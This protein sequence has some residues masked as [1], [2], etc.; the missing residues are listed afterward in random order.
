LIIAAFLLIKQLTF[1]SGLNNQ[2]QELLRDIDAI[3]QEQEKSFQR[4]IEADC[5]V[6]SMFNGKEYQV[7]TAFYIVFLSIFQ[8]GTIALSENTRVL[9]HKLYK[10]S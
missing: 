2:I 7:C 8:R 4:R 9:A 5:T 1:Q 10:S 6:Q 3:R